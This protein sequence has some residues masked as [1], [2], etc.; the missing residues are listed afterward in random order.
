MAVESED[1]KPSTPDLILDAAE[2]VVSRDGARKLTIDAVV[3]ESG[4]SKGG[5]LYNFP[6]KLELVKGMVA[7]MVA[8]YTVRHEAALRQ[9]EAEGGS[10]LR[11]MLETV[12]CKEPKVDRSVSMGLLA[13]IAEHPELIDPIRESMARIR[14]DIIA[15]AGDP[16]LANIV[17]LAAD[18]LHFSHILGLD[19]LS[20]TERGAI[21]ARL[22]TLV[23]EP[24]R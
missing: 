13:A 23:T 11:L 18:G 17:L 14:D 10:P 7:R 12:V 22:L 2:R 9:A 4:F 8:S 19:M 6:S 24:S 21:E 20:E 16:E 3:R 1:V 5:V 15:H